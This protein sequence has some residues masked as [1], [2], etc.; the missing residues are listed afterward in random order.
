[1]PDQIEPCECG[2]GTIDEAGFNA[3]HALDCPNSPTAHL[4]L[5]R[6]PTLVFESPRRV[7]RED[8]ERIK[9]QVKTAFPESKIMVL[10]SGLKVKQMFSHDPEIIAQAFHEATDRDEPFVPWEDVPSGNREVLIAV[11]TKLLEDGVIS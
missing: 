4:L 1:M 3:F 10:E 9:A 2:Y 7:S 8:F 11:F 5:G 6:Q